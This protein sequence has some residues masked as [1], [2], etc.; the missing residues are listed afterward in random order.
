MLVLMTNTDR[1][2]NRSSPRGCIFCFLTILLAICLTV[3][4]AFYQRQYYPVCQGGLS[5]GFP[6]A[7]LC[8]DTGGSPISSWGVIDGADWFNMNLLAFLLD[9]LL[10]GALLSLAWVVIMGFV[11]KGFFQVESFK[12]GVLICIGY[13]VAFLFVFLSF[14]SNSLN[15]E[16]PFPRT[17]T[18]YI[19]APTP[20]P[21]GTPPPPAF[22]PVPTAG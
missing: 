4:S 12:W 18:P 10:N 6:I 7:F 13:I 11:R 14:Q 5:A 20:T 17:P 1:K 15:V 21:F 2:A 8:D 3:G 9:F 22:T 16:I 19:F